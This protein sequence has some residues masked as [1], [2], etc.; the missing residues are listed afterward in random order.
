VPARLLRSYGKSFC[1]VLSFLV[2]PRDRF[3]YIVDRS[4]A[5]HN[6]CDSVGHTALE[7]PLQIRFTAALIYKINT[8]EFNRK[9]LCLPATAIPP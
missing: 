8:Q 6:A 5:G 3:P 4:F 9:P 7:A 1:G 2:P